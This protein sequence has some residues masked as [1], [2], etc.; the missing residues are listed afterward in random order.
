MAPRARST[1]A[2]QLPPTGTVRSV[3]YVPLPTGTSAAL[4][5]PPPC[6]AATRNQSAP[7]AAPAGEIRSETVMSCVVTRWPLRSLEVADRLTCHCVA[8]TVAS[9]PWRGMGTARTART[10]TTAAGASRR[11]SRPAGTEA[12]PRCDAKP[13]PAT[14]AATA[15]RA[16]T[17]IIGSIPGCHGCR[18]Q[19]CIQSHSAATPTVPIS[20]PLS[21]ARASPARTAA[22]ATSTQSAST[23]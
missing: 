20:A 5:T 19:T 6:Q 10:P 22:N 2:F 7:A 14:A 4:T 15:P 18:P 1:I 11:R 23:T 8:L 13:S 12:P 21:R 9:L 16:G 3:T 17:H